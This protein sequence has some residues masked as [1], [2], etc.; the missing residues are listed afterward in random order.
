MWVLKTMAALMALVVLL[1]AGPAAVWFTGGAGSGDWSTASC[2]PAGLAPS[3]A[4]HP[5]AIV[6]LYAA[7]AF[8]WRGAFAVHSWIAFKPRQAADW[9]AFEVQ[10]WRMPTVR[11]R[12]GVP[13]RAWFGQTPQVIAQLEG[14]RAAQAI[15]A[16]KRAARDYPYPQT[17]RAWPG[18][19]SNTFTA[20]VVRR[21]PQLDVALP[22]LAVGKDYLIDDSHPLGR[23]FAPAPSASGYQ[24]SLYGVLGVLAARDEGLEFNLLGLVFGVDP[25]DLAI[26]LPGIGRLT[27]PPSIH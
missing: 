12:S 16:I 4:E 25:L 8:S 22:A 14:E 1:L 3:P 5:G 9:T 23:F 15:P 27:V 24:L 26:K 13:D 6:Q 17:Y 7:R 2:E 20:W 19:N 21:V 11:R 10:G 18:P